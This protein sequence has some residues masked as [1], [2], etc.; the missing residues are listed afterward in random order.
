MRMWKE[1]DP[2]GRC[3]GDGNPRVPKKVMVA[4]G[5]RPEAIKLAPVILGLERERHRFKPYVVATGQHDQMVGQV[6][7]LFQIRPDRNLEIM[8]A[9]Q[10]LFD[11]TAYALRGMESVLK[12][13]RPDIVVVQGDTTTAFVVALA[14]YYEQIAIAHVEAGLR[15]R[16]K[17]NPFPEE[18]N[19]RL[20][21]SLAD[22]HFAPTVL[23]RR[24]L[25]TEGVPVD[26]VFVTGNTVIDA[27]L[28]TVRKEYVF[29]NEL[30]NTIDYQRKKIIIVTMHRRESFGGP[31]KRILMAVS[32][33]AVDYA[34]V[35]IIFPVHFNPRVREI[36]Q[37]VLKDTRWKNIHVVDPLE[38]EAFIQILSRS[39]MVLTD[40]GG[41]QEEAPA[42][43]KPVLVLRDTTERP[44][45]IQEGNARLVG[46]DPSRIYDEVRGLIENVSAYRKMAETKSPYGDGR[47]TERILNILHGM[48]V[49]ETR[50]GQARRRMSE[51][52]SVSTVNNG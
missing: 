9:R 12:E 8:T 1:I 21:G 11:I 34:N 40:S 39:F 17:Y 29:Q 23:A 32:R 30:L 52:R 49:G 16:N 24:Q 31:M 4:F 47:A 38:Y 20:I 42:L 35:E 41:I 5:T 18:M 33:V 6:L 50:L 2:R 51:A 46:T 27:L 22:V 14:A 3:S 43:G 36:V 26:R 10:T 37:R 44:E 25:R 28:M 7:R 13:S 48:S 45:G 19:R 15:T